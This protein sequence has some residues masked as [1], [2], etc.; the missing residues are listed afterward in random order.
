MDSKLAFTLDLNTGHMEAYLVLEDFPLEVDPAGAVHLLYSAVTQEEELEDEPAE[1]G[2]QHESEQE[3]PAQSEEPGEEEE[4]G[5]R[6]LDKQE[7]ENLLRQAAE[8]PP[9]SV[10]GTEQG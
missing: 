9:P 3:P 5:S 1:H 7:L 2:E 10:S 4:G 8:G 6:Q